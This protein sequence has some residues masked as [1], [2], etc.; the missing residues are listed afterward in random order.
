MPR[1]YEQVFSVRDDHIDDLGHVNNLVYLDWVQ[2]IAKAHWAA[3]A[4]PEDQAGTTWV[5]V[6]QEIDYL[7]PAFLGDEV[8]ARTWVE[9]WKGATSHRHTELRRAADGQVLARS[10][11]VWGALD[12][13]SG[14]PRRIP[15]SMR[16]PFLE[17][18]ERLG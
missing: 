5:V 4:R 11:T 2:T 13:E 7:K 9:R 14:K 8:L 1:T 17:D 15:S 3:A 6:R 18:G 10:R 16:D 12:A